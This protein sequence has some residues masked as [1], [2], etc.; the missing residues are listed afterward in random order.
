MAFINPN[1]AKVGELQSRGAEGEAVSVL[2]RSLGNKGSG[3][4]RLSRRVKNMA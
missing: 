1:V 3:A 4:L 2:L